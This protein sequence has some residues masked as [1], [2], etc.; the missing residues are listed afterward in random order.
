M[1]GYSPQFPAVANA[2]F[3]AVGIRLDRLPF[4][5]ARVLAALEAKRSV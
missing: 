4:S 2:I 1:G 5:P 3:D